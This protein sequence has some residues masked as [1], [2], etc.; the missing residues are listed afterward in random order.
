M[1]NFDEYKTY[2]EDFLERYFGVPT[3]RNFKCINPTHNDD[4]P[5]M[6]F[7]KT[8]NRAHCFGCGASYDIFDLVGLYFKIEDKG[9]QF[10][11]VQE[12]YGGGATPKIAK[13]S[14]IV[15][16]NNE[17]PA[18]REE[19]RKYIENCIKNAS[20][21]DYFQKRGISSESVLRF[22]LGY[23]IER[24]AIVI[25][26]NRTYTYYQTR[27]IEDKKFFKP[28]SED[29]G[30]EPLYNA[31]ALKMKNKTPIFIVESPLCAISIMQCGGMA[32]SICGTS[33]ISKVITAVKKKAPKGALILCLDNDEPGQRASLELGDKL[34]E[35]K[36]TFITYNIADECKDPNELLQK[37]AKKLQK[38][39]EKA[40][41]EAK[42]LTFSEFDTFTAKELQDM[43]L[44]PIKWIVK[45][46]LPQ[47]L[48]ILAAPSK[49][50]KSWMMFQLCLAVSQGQT[51]LERETIKSGCWYL[52]LEDSRTRMKDRLL[53]V[54]GP[55][56]LPSNLHISIKAPTLDS[57]LLDLMQVTLEEHK[58]I[59][60]III[61]TLQK[62]RGKID[63]N[64]SVY[65]NDYREMGVLKNFADENQVCILLVHHLR[66]MKDDDIF[67]QISGS[68]GIMGSCDT[69][70]T[71]SKKKRQDED[72]TFSMTGRDIVQ[73]DITITYDKN[74]HKWVKVNN[75]EEKEA[76]KRKQE[77]ENN[78]VIKT[79]KA[80]V[81]ANKYGWKG[82]S[83]D[84]MKQAHDLLGIVLAETPTSIG[85]VIQGYEN[86]LYYDGITHKYNKNKRLHEF[87]DKMTATYNKTFFD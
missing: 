14:K 2:A 20:K 69:V 16:K 26:Y 19:I 56:A 21:T 40:I 3:T 80:I 35:L 53:K 81:K 10:K 30:A 4:K 72:A 87:A 39:I 82:S 66:K 83:S 79:I 70:F 77:Y 29:A 75:A 44:P 11:K 48:A 18:K 84:I 46:M 50:G 61:D 34:K 76:L 65:G 74:S 1:N 22:G 17:K 15:E 54:N 71:I 57:G 9:E 37:N 45:E 67:N 28:K 86:Q 7:D 8:N 73:D 38:N 63:R 27:C 41:F 64:D 23:D 55:G 59:K 36:I 51:F 47:G 5:S 60:L 33:G 42:K 68:T 85:K 13:K 49:A 52:A 31:E 6:S 62:V 12:L 78:D 58:D 43:E 25:P 32:I 24:N